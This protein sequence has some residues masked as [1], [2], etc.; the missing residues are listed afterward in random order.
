MITSIEI[1]N[2]NSIS[3]A[4]LSFAKGRYHYLDEFTLNDAVANPIAIYGRNGSGKSSLLN[5]FNNIISLMTADA[6]SMFSFIPN[7]SDADTGESSHVK[8]CFKLGTIDYEYVVEMDF[9]GIINE[10]LKKKEKVILIRTSDSYEYEGKTHEFQKGFYPALREVANKTNQNNSINRAYSFLSNMAF[11]GGDRKKYRLKSFGYTPYRDK[12][13]EKSSEVKEILRSYGSF[14]V[15]DVFSETDKTGE[16]SYSVR[17][18][19]ENTSFVLPLELASIGMQNQ[20]F[21]LTVLLS[22]PEEGVLI[23]DEL[24]SALHPLSIYNFLKVAVKK[25]VQL[26]FSSHNTNILSKLRPDNVVFSNWKDGS[27]NYHRLSDIYPN[28]REVNNIEKMY[29]SSTFDEEIEK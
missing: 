1:R 19:K 8:I 22:L 11:I 15:Y 28:I 27:S 26:I 4:Y 18:E 24:E 16:K 6:E 5:V 25:G 17:I 23:V 3:N 13:V 9:D 20:S 12:M 29:L 14:P 10:T 2:I 7:L 21:L